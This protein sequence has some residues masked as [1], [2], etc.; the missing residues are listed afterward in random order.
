MIQATNGLLDPTALA[1]SRGRA[2]KALEMRTV[3]NGATL[4]GTTKMTTTRIIC[5]GPSRMAGSPMIQGCTSAVVMIIIRQT[6]Y[7]Y[8]ETPRSSFY[9]HI[10]MAARLLTGGEPQCTKCVGMMKTITI[11]MTGKA[12]IRTMMGEAR[13]TASISAT[14]TELEIT[15]HY[16]VTH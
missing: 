16:V 5:G 6:R 1:G 14:T 11:K 3:F 15:C 7:T 10:W 4:S 8:P 13:I 2:L 9:V 12:H